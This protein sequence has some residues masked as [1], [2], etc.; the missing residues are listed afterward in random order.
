MAYVRRAT[1]KGHTYY[2]LVESYREG[3]KVRQRILEYYGKNPPPDVLNIVKERPDVTAMART[4]AEAELTPPEKPTLG[5]RLKRFGR[6][7]WS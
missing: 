7:L 2:Y 1:V 3:K 4:L 5:Q 6:S